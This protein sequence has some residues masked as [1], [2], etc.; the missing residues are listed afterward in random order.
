MSEYADLEA[1]RNGHRWDDPT[2]TVLALCDAVEWMRDRLTELGD[3]ES[4]E[5]FHPRSLLCTNC[6]KPMSGHTP[7]AEC[8][9]AEEQT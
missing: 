5:R 8:W 1:I 6:G 2:P 9:T 7:L 4:L 3:A